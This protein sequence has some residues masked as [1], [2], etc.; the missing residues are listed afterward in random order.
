MALNCL[1]YS[2]SDAFGWSTKE[3]VKMESIGRISLP[4]NELFQYE[5]MED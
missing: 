1:W 4:T 3:I 2:L 5:L